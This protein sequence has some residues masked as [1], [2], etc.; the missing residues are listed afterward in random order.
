MM[1]SESA[2]RV[3]T[4]LDEMGVNITRAIAIRVV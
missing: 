4:V 3:Q 2:K 1:L